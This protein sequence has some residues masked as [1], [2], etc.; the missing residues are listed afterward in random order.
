MKAKYYNKPENVL[1]Y[2]PT[3]RLLARIF[4]AKYFVIKCKDCK[5]IPTELIN[6]YC[7][8]CLLK[9]K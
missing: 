7:W 6:G 2:N 3:T 9:R 1:F 4:G 8:D 5:Q